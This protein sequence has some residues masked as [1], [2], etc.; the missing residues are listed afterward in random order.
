MKTVKNIQGLIGL[1]DL[2]SRLG[3]N[4]ELMAM[5]LAINLST[6]KLCELGLRSLPTHALIRVAELEIRLASG[7]NRQYFK[8]MHE[9]EKSM[10]G[11]FRKRY[12]QLFSKEKKCEHDLIICTSHLKTMVDNYQK[13][14]T[15]LKIN[16]EL[17]EA[18]TC[19]GFH[20]DN[21][22][23]REELITNVLRKCGLAM[24]VLYKVKI[25]MLETELK[26]YKKARVM[27]REALPE[28]FTENNKLIS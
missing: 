2:R 4:Q 3:F 27:I 13:T 9:A 25:E 20:I 10:P 26:A 11:S 1:A 17:V 5:Y 15:G 21:T 23:N 14:R 28:Y 24:Q 16:D 8:N 18:N 22:E 12:D 19:K 7:C 6:L